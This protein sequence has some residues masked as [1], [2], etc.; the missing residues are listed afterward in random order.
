MPDKVVNI[1]G[2][3]DARFKRIDLSAAERRS[4]MQAHGLHKTVYLLGGDAGRQ[5]KEPGR[6]DAGV[7]PPAAGIARAISVAG[8]RQDEFGDVAIGLK[9]VSA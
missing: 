9:E 3:A 7:C 6:S 5:S 2:A 4:I 8:R 1:G